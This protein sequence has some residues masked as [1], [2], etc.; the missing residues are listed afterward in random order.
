M[1]VMN[2]DDREGA[3]LMHIAQKEK[4][5]AIATLICN[6]FLPRHFLWLLLL[7]MTMVSVQQG[8]EKTNKKERTTLL[9]QRFE[10]DP[11]LCAEKD[12]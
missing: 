3:V 11:V 5:P 2:R 8:R 9:L 10:V 6:S 12:C 1:L 7:G 4:R